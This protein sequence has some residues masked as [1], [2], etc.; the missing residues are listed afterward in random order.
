MQSCL[1]VRHSFTMGHL[2]GALPRRHTLE[3]FTE[4]KDFLG[5]RLV[6]RIHIITDSPVLGTGETIS[7][8]SDDA[9]CSLVQFSM[10]RDFEHDI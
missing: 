4:D 3:S 2:S 6:L 7:N 1:L 9:F 10:K 5:N 8:I